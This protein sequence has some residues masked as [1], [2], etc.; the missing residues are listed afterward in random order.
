[1]TCA[2]CAARIERG[3]NRLDGVASASVNLAA[4]RATVVYDPAVTGRPAFEEKVAA[5]G[6]AVGRD[7][8]L[9]DSDA[10]DPERA[11]RSRLLAGA[12]L[13]AP[14]LLLGMIPALQYPGWAWLA[15][16]LATPVVLWAGSGFHRAALAGLRHRTATMDTLVSLGTLAAWGWSMAALLATRPGQPAPGEPG[17]PHLYFEVAAIIVVVVLFGRWLEQRAR[18]RSG[19]ALR[20]LLELGSGTAMVLRDGAE[21]P[22]PVEHVAVGDR[23]VVRPGQKLATDGV[24]EEGRS[25]IDR[26]LLTGESVPVE[27]GPGDEVTGAT[28]NLE[29]RLVVRATR[30]GADTALAQIVRLVEA[31]QGS[32]APVQRLADRVAGV[33]VP[34]VLVIAALTF[35]GWLVTGHSAAEAVSAAVAVLIVACPCSLGLA[36]PTAVMV[37]TGRGAQLGILI[38]GAEVLERAG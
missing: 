16:V 4:E 10:D 5:L 1:M 21:V 28:V 11:Q 15:A 36:T 31:A 33:F 22:V 35:A 17:G 27:A 20:H 30:V 37:G 29:G 32:K 23:F 13:A 6:Y 2:A 19:Q 14:V 8:G 3:L 12:A 25:S 9:G 7:P 24:V 34:V 38:R 18:R 26:S